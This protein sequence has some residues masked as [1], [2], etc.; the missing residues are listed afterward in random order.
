MEPHILLS[1][2]ILSLKDLNTGCQ[3]GYEQNKK[4]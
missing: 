1:C 4:S 2:H 3:H